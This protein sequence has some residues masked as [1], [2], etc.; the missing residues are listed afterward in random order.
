MLDLARTVAME[1]KP[2]RMI[3]IS[4]E[5]VISTG[6]LVMDCTIERARAAI[7]SADFRMVG[8][9]ILCSISSPPFGSS[10][11]EESLLISVSIPHA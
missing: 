7:A 11:N 10:W 9:T 6:L 2:R 3:P 5:T 1:R 8:A 4:F